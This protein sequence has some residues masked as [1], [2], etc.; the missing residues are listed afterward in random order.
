MK[1][2]GY[3]HGQRAQMS[4]LVVSYYRQQATA[5]CSVFQ[6]SY[7]Y[8]PIRP[9]LFVPLLLMAE[10]L[11]AAGVDGQSDPRALRKPNTPGEFFTWGSLGTLGGATFGTLLIS[12]GIQ[13]AFNYN[14]RWLALFVA[15]IICLA[16]AFYSSTGGWDTYIIAV[17]NGFLVYSSAVGT[18]QMTGRNNHEPGSGGGAE[19]RSFR[20][21][22][23]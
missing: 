18:A 17:V 14:P 16:T 3:I 12:N 15:E 20:S 2:M 23:F 1:F 6:A 11:Q 8:V 13:S 9:L 4:I 21:R 10:R 19:R 7:D 22:W 5:F